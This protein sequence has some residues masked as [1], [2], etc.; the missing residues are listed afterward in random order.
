MILTSMIMMQ[1]EI[2]RGVLTP[3]VMIV[4]LTQPCVIFVYQRQ[5]VV[6]VHVFLDSSHQLLK[7]PSARYVILLVIAVHLLQVVLLASLVIILD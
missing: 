3:F 4:V 6:H 7:Q 1:M 2:A 5:V